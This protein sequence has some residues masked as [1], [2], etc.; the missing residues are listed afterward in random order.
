MRRLLILP[1][2]WA[3]AE[4]VADELVHAA[5][6]SSGPFFIALSGGR[7]PL[8]LYSLLASPDA[9]YCARM[10]WR[11]LHFF[12]GDERCVPIQDPAS[13]FGAAWDE[14]LGRVPVPPDN[15]HRVM[16]ERDPE[17][18]ARGYEADLRREMGPKPRFDWVLLGI[19]ADGHT[20]SLFPRA[21]ALREKNRLAVASWAPS[22]Q[23]RVTLTLPVLNAAERAVF[24]VSG[25][26]KAEAVSWALADPPREDVPASLVRPRWLE[27]V[28][29]R[30]AAGRLEPIPGA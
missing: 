13:N 4:T 30:D 9:P 22:G 12:W 3:A 17:E 10:P 24:L 8:A 20:A 14:M 15:I 16:G 28:L 25:V 18:A 1:D 29:D 2:L 5:A 21:P 23:A 27:W 19:G 7:T 26:K 6:S 11:R